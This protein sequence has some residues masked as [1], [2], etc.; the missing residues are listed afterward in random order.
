[1]V[2]PQS[3]KIRPRVA[4]YK[5]RLE[6]ITFIIWCC[7]YKHRGNPKYNIVRKIFQTVVFRFHSFSSRQMCTHTLSYVWRQPSNSMKL[8]FSETTSHPNRV[9]NL[10]RETFSSKVQNRKTIYV[11]IFLTSNDWLIRLE[12]KRGEIEVRQIHHLNTSSVPTSLFLRRFCYTSC[13]TFFNK[14]NYLSVLAVSSI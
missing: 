12:R 13:V 5:V 6:N 9:V 14:I 1:M 3:G 10:H 4:G 8:T 7:Q 11:I 2:K